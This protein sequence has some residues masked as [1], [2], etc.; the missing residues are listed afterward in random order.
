MPPSKAGGLLNVTGTYI[1]MFVI[2]AGILLIA[3]FLLA[4]LGSPKPLC[5]VHQLQGGDRSHS[6][7]IVHTNQGRA[8]RLSQL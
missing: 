6:V 2:L 8:M 4:F 1:I 3:G 5:T 7:R